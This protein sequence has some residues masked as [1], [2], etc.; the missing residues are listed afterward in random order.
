[1]EVHKK[2]EPRFA[3]SLKPILPLLARPS[4][5]RNNQLDD[6]LGSDDMK[7]LNTEQKLIINLAGEK[8]TGSV[9]I[10]KVNLD[11][12]FT[13]DS[14][15]NQDQQTDLEQTKCN[16]LALTS[17]KKDGRNGKNAT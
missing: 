7:N 11:G 17:D 13:V 15:D 2:S 10:G 5:T 6:T 3:R 9:S 14:N 1:M 16:Y 8:L 12:S 4:G